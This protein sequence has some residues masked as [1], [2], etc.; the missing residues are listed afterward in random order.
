MGE[1]TV[2]KYNEDTVEQAA[3]LWL[4]ELGYSHIYGPDIDPTWTNGSRT[5]FYKVPFKQ[6]LAFFRK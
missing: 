6:K 1:D 4:Q 3:L 5:N 2:S